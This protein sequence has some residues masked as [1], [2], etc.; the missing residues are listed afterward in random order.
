MN[1][2]DQT[3]VVLLLIVKFSCAFLALLIFA[4]LVPPA[5]SML[6]EQS[7]ERGLI[8]QAQS[9][10]AEHYLSALLDKTR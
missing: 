4:E 10:A 2:Q 3:P 9:S 8:A 7:A 6:A 5:M 1:S